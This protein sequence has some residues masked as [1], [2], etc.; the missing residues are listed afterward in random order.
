MTGPRALGLRQHFGR[1]PGDDRVRVR[2]VVREPGENADHLW[3]ERAEQREEFVTDAVAG[4]PRVGVRRIL[5]ERLTQFDSA[6]L[7][8]GV[9]FDATPRT[10]IGG[11]YGYQ[12]REGDTRVSTALINLIQRF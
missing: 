12:R 3:V 9:R 1:P 4:E 2:S 8:A 5:A 7:S 6:N 10:S 11:A